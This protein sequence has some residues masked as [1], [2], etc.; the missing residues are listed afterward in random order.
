[1]LSISKLTGAESLW[2]IDDCNVWVSSWHFTS[3]SKKINLAHLNKY[4]NNP[5][6]SKD[7]YPA[8]HS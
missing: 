6:N 4:N 3:S 1:M 7:Y 5:G 2:Y 8:V